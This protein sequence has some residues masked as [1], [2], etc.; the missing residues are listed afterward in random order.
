MTG[1]DTELSVAVIGT[2][3][4]SDNADALS[5]AYHHANAYQSINSCTLTACADIVDENVATFAENYNLDS[6]VAYTDHTNLLAEVEP[7]IVSVCVPPAAHPDIVIDCANHGVGAVHC[8]KPMALTW[9]EAKEMTDACRDAGVQLTFNH[10]RR[11][12]TQWQHAAKL[13]KNGEIGE[14][15]RIEMRAPNLFDWGT[16]CFDLCGMYADE[17]PPEWVLGQIDYTKENVVYGA[18]QENRAIA[19]WEYKNGI[20]GLAL[21][22]KASSISG[23]YHRIDGTKGQIEVRSRH[24][25]PALRVRKNRTTGWKSGQVESS[26]F[27]EMVERAISDVVRSFRTGTQS[28][29]SVL[30]AL[31]ATEV[32][33][34]TWESARK[35]GVVEFPL[36]ITD[37]P[38]EEMVNSGA[39]NPR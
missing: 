27:A 32:I 23:S 22:G 38:L 19:K 1:D 36:Q 4:N 6:G 24:E 12:G 37:N 20:E 29:L 34:G 13:L 21:T 8:E 7:D 35:R 39:L 16:H 15:Q 9:G 28:S 26:P 31:R 5:M 30:N 3:P 17:S 10:Q 2:G 11:F 18:H 33:F 25:G 14:L